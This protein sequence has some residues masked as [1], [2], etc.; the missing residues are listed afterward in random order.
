M[1]QNLKPDLADIRRE[2]RLN[3]SRKNAPLGIYTKSAPTSVDS[4]SNTIR[5]NRAVRYELLASA[6]SLFI[7]EG[8]KDG[9]K[10]P[11]NWH[12][13]AKCKHINI[14]E[15][16]VHKSHEH[17]SA[18]YSG[19]MT[20][21]SVWTCPV[22]SAVV[23]ERRRV[24]IGKAVAWAYET[25][26]Q[27]AM[28][29]LTFPHYKQN[30]LD[31]L[32]KKQ[33]DALSRFRRGNVWTLF[34][35][36]VGFAGLIRALELTHGDNGWHPHTHELWFVDGQKNIADEKA[37]IVERW[38]KCCIKAGLVDADN[39]AQIAAFRLHGVDIK[40]R[41]DASDYLA[42]NDAAS[43]WGV[44]RELAKATSKAGKANGLHPFG[45]LALARDGDKVAGAKFVEYSAV[46]RGKRQ[47]FWSHGLKDLVGVDEVTDEEL[48]AQQEDKAD[49]L[50]FITVQQWRWVRKA[51]LRAQLL[52]A[53]ELSGWVGVEAII[54]CLYERPAPD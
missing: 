51:G 40:D 31:E 24:E 5:Q 17:K 39:A 53:A 29:T 33:A 50:G 7:D 10:H 3:R 44:D 13:T 28:I 2:K 26:K 23:Q 30:A 35:N 16:G 14:A 41:C 21:G 22:C 45:L 43:H 19:L 1:A 52:D 47:L 38:L 9:L 18:F 37:F 49:L 27:A 32:I 54:N 42:K 11:H 8:H 4:V 20:C 25:G 15:I 48:A 34:R 46:M 6:R 12:R 36:R